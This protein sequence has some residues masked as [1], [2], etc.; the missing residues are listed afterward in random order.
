MSKNKD[1]LNWFKDWFDSPYYH[2]LYK[3]RDM[4]EAETFIANLIHYLKPLKTDHLLDVA[5]GKGRHA[6]TMNDLGFCV[7]AFD[8]SENSIISAKKFENERLSFYV[9]DIRK[10]IKKNYYNFAFN[11]FTS[12]GYFDDDNDNL[13][14]IN[15]I[16]ESLKP[17]GK[18]VLDFMNATKIVKDLVKSELKIIEGITFNITKSIVNGFIVKQIDFVDKGNSY[19]FQERVKI[20]TQDDFIRYFKSA[21]LKIEATFGDYTL[22][23]F[24]ENTSE[25]LIIIAKK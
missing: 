21:N 25:R 24:D 13:L 11:L 17:N 6:K 12:F 16:A 4:I 15:A 23:P 22:N 18:L 10:P 20:I 1:N 5:C 2:I 3:N 9:N 14:A 19:S 7:E 8:L